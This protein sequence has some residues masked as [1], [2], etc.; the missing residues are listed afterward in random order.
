MEENVFTKR[1]LEEDSFETCPQVT[2]EFISFN[3]VEYK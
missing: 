1:E 3:E 2:W